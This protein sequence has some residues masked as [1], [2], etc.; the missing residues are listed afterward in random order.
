MNQKNVILLADDDPVF[1]IMLRCFLSQNG[2][3]VIEANDGREAV[4]LFLS[5]HVDLVLLDGDMPVMDGFKACQQMHQ[6]QKEIPI[7]MITSSD[8]HGFIDQAFAAGAA[9]YVHKPIHKQLLHHRIGYLLRISQESKYLQDSE[10]RFRNL[11]EDAPLAYQTLDHDDYVMSVNP[12][13]LNLLGY[14]QEDVVSKSFDSFLCDEFKPVFQQRFQHSEEKIVINDLYLG[15]LKKNG[16]RVDVELSGRVIRSQDGQFRHSQGI[17]VN[18]TERKQREVEMKKLTSALDQAGNSVI[19]TDLKGKIQYVNQ[20]FTNI[21]GYLLDEVIGKNP[22]MLQSGMQKKSFY[23]KMWGSILETGEWMGDLKNKRKNGELYAERLH[24]RVLHD[25]E[26]K[27]INYVGVFSDITEQLE[28]EEQYRQSQ[29]MAAI[30]TLVG[31]VA[32]NFNNMLA[33]IVGKTFLAKLEC[34][35]ENIN[36]L[37]I[38]KELD[39]IENIGISAGDMVHQLLAFARKGITKKESVHVH[40]IMQD[41]IDV[42]K[43][44][45]SLSITLNNEYCGGTLVACVDR[46]QLQQ[47]LI[48]LINNARDALVLSSQK[49]IT[50]RL[51]YHALKD[52]DASF[53]RK[54]PSVEAEHLVLF[55]VEDSGEGIS[56][57]KIKNIFD[58]FFTT[59]EVGSGTGLGLSMAVGVAEDHG[60][61]IDVNSELGKG[62]CFSLWIP[63][64]SAP[65]IISTHPSSALEEQDHAI[66]SDILLL[67][68]DDDVMILQMTRQLLEMLGFHVITA[69]DG[70]EAVSLFEK[71]L[72]AIQLVVSDVIMPKLD[73]PS[74]VAKMREKKPMLPVVFITGYDK[75]VACVEG[76][77]EAITQVRTKPF[78]IDELKQSIHMLLGTHDV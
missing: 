32:H 73:G 40:K 60:G 33:G 44:G 25:G 61:A 6:Y 34:A 62:A 47:T 35:E 12:A 50:T 17:L 74:A 58:P 64:V 28:L 18:V 51:Q 31:G 77:H 69:C 56:K 70:E 3:D 41:A 46:S 26:G 27:C 9:D 4:D 2:Y 38:M 53:R 42:A 78:K 45:L 23:T 65:N 57:E 55:Q 19:V 5:E 68:V 39:D 14:R 43:I 16:E 66:Q 54:H 59:K 71:H 24:I 37:Q 22:S 29:K 15:M 8:E 7:I 11:F 63:L 36:P 21:T 67:L 13:W 30:G 75:T 1:C 52:M 10:V 48:N 49:T 20:E 76:K 72:D